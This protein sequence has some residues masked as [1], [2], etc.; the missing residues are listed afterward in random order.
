MKEHYAHPISC[1]LRESGMEY[2]A[3]L[4]VKLWVGAHVGLE[5]LNPKFK[6]RP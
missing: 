5:P 4:F 2:V 6:T 3:G 1:L